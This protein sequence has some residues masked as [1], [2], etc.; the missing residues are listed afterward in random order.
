MAMVAGIV[1]W[2]PGVAHSRTD[3]DGSFGP[4]RNLWIDRHVLLSLPASGPAWDRL[5][6]DA[7]G[8]WGRANIS[9]QDSD[10]DVL[11]LAGALYAVRMNDTGMRSRV[12]SA[13]ESAVGTEAGGRTLALGRNLTGYVLAADLVGYDS[14]EFRS[15]LSS[16]R[17][18]DLDGQTLIDTHETRPNNWGTHAGAAR[19]AVDL[20][21]GD[22]SDL[23]RAVTVFQGFLGDRNAYTGFKFGTDTWQADPSAPVPINPMGAT[24]NG[25]N[26]DGAIVDDIRRCE[27]SVSSPAPKENYQWE[28]MQGIATQAT[29]LHA[30]GRTAVWTWS[31]SAIG[32]AARFLF[33]QARYPAEG[34]DTAVLFLLDAGLGT[35][36]SAGVKANVAKSIAYTDVT[37]P[38]GSSAATRSTII[39]GI[40]TG[41]EPRA[42]DLMRYVPVQQVRL[43]DTRTADWP[44][45]RPS[46]GQTLDIAVAGQAGIP[47]SGVG[48]VLLNVTATNASAAGFIAVWPTGDPRP[49]TSNLNVNGPGEVVPNLVAVPL[50]DNGRVSFYTHVSVD[51]VADVS[52]YFV[53]DVDARGG[54][55]VPIEPARVFDTRDGAAPGGPLGA[56]S[57]LSVKVTDRFGL[58]SSGAA[59]AVINLTAVGLETPGFIT[60]FPHGQARPWASSLNFGGAGSVRANLVFAPIGSGGSIDFFSS[61]RTHLI[62]D[63]V[64]YFTDDSAERSSRGMFVATNSVRHVDTRIGLPGGAGR[65]RARGDADYRVG[66]NANVPADNV[67]AVFAN[68]TAT[69]AGS[70]HLTI[71]ATGSSRPPTSSLNL[72]GSGTTR[73]NA[74]VVPLGSGGEVSVY[75]H[76]D[77]HVVLDVFGYFTG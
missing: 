10:H 15:W 65:I 61:A 71:W 8:E 60:T 75:S 1:L 77:A 33:E 51:L 14:G 48:A 55:F 25:I 11:A 42:T 23:D 13:I 66:G 39:P 12:V 69:E 73:A 37:H 43:F 6:S 35:T 62:A 34:D 56:G 20:F 30:A 74:A 38:S 3:L 19:I 16:V 24:K 2:L 40:V 22:T 58:P 4:T 28:A 9:D 68:L 21:V 18:I 41:S 29:L 50:G 31:D 64:G 36:Y 27:C 26:V 72:D 17:N 59:V 49:P 53:E 45:G 47:S 54:R 70:G 44:S 7:R 46:A 52:G 67:R 63:V 5:A 32:R 76:G 57:T